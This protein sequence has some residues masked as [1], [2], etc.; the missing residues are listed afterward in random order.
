MSIIN[1]PSVFRTLVDCRIERTRD[2]F[3]L[4]D[5]G[6]HQVSIATA[7]WDEDALLAVVESIA[8]TLRA[9]GAKVSDKARLATRIVN[10]AP[11]QGLRV[12]DPPPVVRPAPTP[13]PAAEEKPSPVKV[14]TKAPKKKG[15]S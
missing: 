7:F 6:N 2:G 11:T 3:L 5:A 1:A 8:A 9:R 15:K 12:E 13:P 10:E 4:R 14:A